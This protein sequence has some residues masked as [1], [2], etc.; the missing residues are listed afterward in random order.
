MQA[1]VTPDETGEVLD[2]GGVASLLRCSERHV[3]ALVA[4]GDFIAPARLGVLVRWRRAAVLA[5]L[6][7]KAGVTVN[8][9]GK[10]VQVR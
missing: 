9:G 4:N 2:V 6:D 8:R 10:L 1:T 7:K 5:W 3:R